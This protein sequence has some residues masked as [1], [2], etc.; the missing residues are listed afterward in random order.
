KLVAEYKGAKEDGWDGTYNG[1]AMPST[2]YWYVIDVE[3]IDRQF[4]GHFTLIRQ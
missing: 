4:M 3:E 1:H 2:D